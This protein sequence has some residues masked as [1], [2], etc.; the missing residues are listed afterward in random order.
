[1]EHVNIV[2]DAKPLG[3]LW[4]VHDITDRKQRE[5]DL[6]HLAST[7]ALTNLPNRR[8]FM[9]NFHL[10]H[11]QARL[12]HQDLGMVMMLDIDRFKL[13]NDTYGH[14]VGDIVLQEV[15]RILRDTIRTTDTPARLGGEE[16]AVLLPRSDV[17]TGTAIAERIRTRIEESPI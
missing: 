5:L 8:S 6:T 7:D 16:F 13:V 1:I 3:S 11:D 12:K 15:A 9:Q 17:A 14:V 4:L 2:Q 10:Q